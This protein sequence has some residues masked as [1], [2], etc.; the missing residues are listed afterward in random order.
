MKQL[1][2]RTLLSSL[3]VM[4]SI[5]V[6]S[7]IGASAS[8]WKQSSNG[9]WWYDKG[10]SYSINWEQINGTWY[11]FGEDGVMKTGWIE[12]GG[13]W[14]YLTSSGAMAH[15]TYIGSY[16]VNA[17]G[18][19]STPANNNTSA[20]RPTTGSNL[21]GTQGTGGAQDKSAEKALHNGSSGSTSTV[22]ADGRP[23]TA[24]GNATGTL[25]SGGE[26]DKESMDSAHRALNQK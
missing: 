26:Q 8:E 15:D 6:L 21:T 17:S 4:A 14:Y 1:K 25:G 22:G 3:L 24:R 9:N 13:N 2:L 10:S 11:F 20:K 5:T 23:T 16:Y 7:P 19:W 18:Q 12:D